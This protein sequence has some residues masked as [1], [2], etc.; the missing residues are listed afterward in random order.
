MSNV[1]VLNGTVYYKNGFESRKTGSSNLGRDDFLKILVT[2]LS[3][4][5]PTQPLQDKDFI[6]QMAVFTQVEQITNMAEEMRLLRQSIGWSSSLIGKSIEWRRKNPSTGEEETVKG[7]VTSIRI[8]NGIQYAEVDG[9]QVSLDQILKIE[10]A[11]SNPTDPAD[12]TDP[13]DPTDPTD[14]AD[15]AD[16]S[17]PSDPADSSDPN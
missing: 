12:P 15:P 16:P 8:K 9:N 5:D 2:Q 4:Q 13:V 14:P 17:D 3:N 1:G 6:A 7:I 11:V 10:E